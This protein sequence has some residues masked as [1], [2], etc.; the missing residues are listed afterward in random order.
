[1]KRAM[2]V[3]H[4]DDESLWGSG[5]VMRYPGDW[6]IICCTTPRSD[7]VR[8][9]KFL[10]ACAVLG[11]KPVIMQRVEPMANEPITNF[12]DID[13][14]EYGHIVTHNA[15]GEYGHLQHKS[16]HRFVVR[17]YGKKKLTFFGY[18]PGALSGVHRIYLTEFEQ[19]RKMKALKCYNHLHPYNGQNMP[20]W[21]ALLHRYMTTEGIPF[22]VETYD[23]TMP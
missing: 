7:P 6:T 23:G 2:I 17:N 9:E 4:P 12:D 21:E 15:F 8:A 18:R 1:M 14:S 5:I 11:A 16:V 20:K 22:H 3:A 10:D 13:L 19:A